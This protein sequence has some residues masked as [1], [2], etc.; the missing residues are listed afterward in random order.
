M[1]HTIKSFCFCLCMFCMAIHVDVIL[2]HSVE[3]HLFT[4]PEN[5]V[6]YLDIQLQPLFDMDAVQYLNF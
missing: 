6:Q 1:S 3:D 2:H 5:P 4:Q